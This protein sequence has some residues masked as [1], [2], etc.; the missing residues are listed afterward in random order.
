MSRIHDSIPDLYSKILKTLLNVTKF[1][2][3]LFYSKCEI[4]RTV[5]HLFSNYTFLLCLFLW[6]ILQL[7][8]A[9][10]EPPFY[11]CVDNLGIPSK[12]LLSEFNFGNLLYRSFDS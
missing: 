7:L 12:F 6:E 3:P 8:F 1:F 4:L 9:G 10:D 11:F 5:T 2:L